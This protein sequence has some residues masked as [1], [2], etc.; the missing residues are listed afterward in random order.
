[1]AFPSRRAA[2]QKFR[3]NRDAK[4]MPNRG[5]CKCYAA[6]RSIS[7]LVSR[8][9]SPIQLDRTSSLRVH[10]N[11][12]QFDIFC[13]DLARSLTTEADRATIISRTQSNPP[14]ARPSG[15]MNPV[16]ACECHGDGSI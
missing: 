13:R 10:E 12:C 16:G 9:H 11:R 3:K 15:M 6:F 5:G 7:I 4:P 2:G 14:H 8:L 1:M